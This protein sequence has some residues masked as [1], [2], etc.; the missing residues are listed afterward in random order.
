MK[1]LVILISIPLSAIVITWSYV[2]NTNVQRSILITPSG[3]DLQPSESNSES[4]FRHVFCFWISNVI[5]SHVSSLPALPRLLSLHH[6]P[7]TDP[8]LHWARH[9]NR[10][11]RLFPGWPGD[12]FHFLISLLITLSGLLC[13]A[14]RLPARQIGGELGAE[15][16]EGRWEAAGHF[17][18]GLDVRHCLSVRYHFIT[19]S[20]T[21]SYQFL[22][23]TRCL[24][25]YSQRGTTT[26]QSASSFRHFIL[27]YV[28]LK[29]RYHFLSTS[30][31]F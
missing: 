16:Q 24:A 14:N 30:Y 29:T 28:I 12:F 22:I 6:S 8:L 7:S 18:F 21:L 1:S 13:T 20:R 26:I 2:T 3:H 27:L 15:E 10:F 4:P 9:L 25:T 5:W 17:H 23:I 19:I 11:A 31:Q